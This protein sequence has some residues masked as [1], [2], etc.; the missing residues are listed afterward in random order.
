[1]SQADLF[2]RRLRPIM[3]ALV[4]SAVTVAVLR[5]PS[6]ERLSS[7][8][9]AA[10]HH[11]ALSCD[12][13]HQ[14]A[15]GTTR[16]QIQANLRA[17]IGLREGGAP[18]CTDPVD[19]R[20]CL[21]CHDNRADAHPVHLFMEPR[22][23]AARSA[24]H[25][26]SCRSCHSE[27]ETRL[28]S[29]TGSFCVHCHEDLELREDPA[30]PTHASLVE[31]ERFDTCLQCHDYHGSHSNETP[32]RLVDAPPLSTITSYLAGEDVRPYGALKQEYPL[33]R[34]DSR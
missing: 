4:V 5:T 1:M 17:W 7:P 13:C 28:T 3:S 14:A 25:P 22:F 8:G 21:A 20:D 32:T 27:H 19:N 2:R 24:I 16:Q 34:A 18:L 29:I 33:E 12:Q 9:G 31:A 26:E 30:T 23:E 15:P 6:N 11:G 10:D